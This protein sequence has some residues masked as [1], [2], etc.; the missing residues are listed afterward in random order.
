M[1]PATFQNLNED[2]TSF[3]SMREMFQRIVQ[4]ETT[5]QEST[6][7]HED[8]ERRHA[9]AEHQLAIQQPFADEA[10]IVASCSLE[11][12]RQ[13]DIHGFERKG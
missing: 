1:F 5:Q 10:V 4:L 13:D 2:G 12:W 8:A 7:R 6:R 11:D 9:D 3:P